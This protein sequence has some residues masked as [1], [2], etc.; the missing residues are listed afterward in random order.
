MIELFI[1]IKIEGHLSNLTFVL[2]KFASKNKLNSIIDFKIEV[3]RKF[4]LVYF[5]FLKFEVFLER[6]IFI[7]F[8]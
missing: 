5:N 6:G 8:F 3:I 1:Y 4:I 2:L 7:I